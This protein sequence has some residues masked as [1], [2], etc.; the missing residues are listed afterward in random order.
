[1]RDRDRSAPVVFGEPFRARD[2][3][4]M[5]VAIAGSWL[6]ARSAARPDISISVIPTLAA[7]AVRHFKHGSSEGEHEPK[8]E[9]VKFLL[10]AWNNADFDEAEQH[11]GPACEIYMNGLTDGSG[12][13]GD[14][15]AT[16]KQS[17]EYWRAIVP[18]LKMELSQEIR[19]K[20]R[21]AI[22]WRVTG[23]HTGAVPELPAS[24]NQIDIEGSAF[25]LLEDDKIVEVWTVFDS[26]SLAIQMGATEA[27]AWWPGHASP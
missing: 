24:G 22:E 7:L 23:T 21:I 3:L 27:P 12:P 13:K 5:A 17:V 11:V 26:L 2:I 15:P 1:M 6:V 14:G 10:G 4:F 8:H 19:E 9:A 25:L 16:L 18:D 20:H